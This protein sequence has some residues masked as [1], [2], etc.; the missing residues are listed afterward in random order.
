VTTGF[1]PATFD[2]AG[3]VD[4]C[5]S[6]H[7]NVFAI[8]KSVGHVPTN[9][10]CGVCHNTSTFIGAVFDHTGIVD[11]CSSCHGV[12]AT[13]KHDTH[14]STAL[15]CHYCHTT[16]TFVGG[17]W[18]HDASTAGQCNTC[19]NGSTATGKS[20]GHLS[21]TEQCDVCHSTDAWAPDIFRH[22]ASGDYPGDHRRNPGCTACHGSTISS[23]VPY[24]FPR[25]APFCAA[26]HAGD[27]SS[28][29]DHIGGRSG[30]VEQ[31][32]NCGGSGCHSVNQF[33][34]D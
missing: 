21:T 12:T 34:W 11:N 32:K 23:S 15:D 7:N 22:S 19:H 10:D 3:I 17:S 24:P 28:E 30:T 4:N 18:F 6:C 26:C 8:G 20:S 5:R 33:N 13:G 9:Q 31:N 27:F 16:A 29:S 2:H 25:Y 1:R 14:I